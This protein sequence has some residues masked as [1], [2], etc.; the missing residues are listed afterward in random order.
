[1]SILYGFGERRNSD[2]STLLIQAM[3]ESSL[4]NNSWRNWRITNMKKKTKSQ[5]KKQLDKVFSQF[6]RW[7][8]ADD[9]GYVNCFTCG[10]KKKAFGVGCIQA[11]HFQSRRHMSLRWD[12]EFGNVQPQCSYCNVL[13][14]GQQFVFARRIDEIHGN[15]RALE[16]EQMAKQTKKFTISD[17]EELIHIYKIK[18][19]DLT[20]E[21]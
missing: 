19:K 12:S 15:G 21:S 20:S 14:S 2:A 1:M 11:G 13:C 3:K 8:D 9:S 4:Q 16:L 18:V 10:A 7:K 6:I 17:L 5:L